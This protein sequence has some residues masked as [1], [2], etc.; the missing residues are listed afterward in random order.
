MRQDVLLKDAVQSERLGAD[1]ALEWTLSS[2]RSHVSLKA[3][4]GASVLAAD[5]ALEM[6]A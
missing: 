1:V 5:V 4:F 6:A 3:L 2:V